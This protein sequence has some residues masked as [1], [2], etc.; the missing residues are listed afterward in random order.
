MPLNEVYSSGFDSQS[1]EQST[2]WA[3]AIPELEW[4]ET[5]AQSIAGEIIGRRNEDY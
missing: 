1:F 3:D 2:D 5:E 4:D